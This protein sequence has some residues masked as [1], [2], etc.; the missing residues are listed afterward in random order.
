MLFKMCAFMMR[1]NCSLVH[2]P[3]QI[4]EMHG[5]LQHEMPHPMT[6]KSTAV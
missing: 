6:V 1:E 4:I 2:V 3:T 5:S